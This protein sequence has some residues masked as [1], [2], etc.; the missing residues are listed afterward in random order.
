MEI[1]I[2]KNNWN[3][4]INY[5]QAA[6]DM[7]KA[8]IGGMAVCVEDEEGDW[9]IERPIILKQEISGGNCILDKEELAKYY[10]K[11]GMSKHYKNKNYRFLWWHSHHTMDAFWSATDLTAIQ[12]FNEGDFSFALVVNL[13]QEYKLRVS[14]WQPFEIHKDVDLN[15]L[16]KDKKVP[17]N[18][19]DEVE[20]LCDTIKPYTPN[21]SHNPSK[22]TSQVTMFQS[23]QTKEEKDFEKTY[24]KL[25]DAI[26]QSAGEVISKA[27]SFD[28]FANDLKK[29]D[30]QLKDKNLGIR[31]NIPNEQEM[32]TLE[33]SFIIEVDKKFMMLEKALI[34]D[35]LFDNGYTN[36]HYSWGML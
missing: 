26:E 3:K 20:L 36:S 5:A 32:Y 23:T 31:V 22:S 8:E 21:Y 17:K 11:I 14:V 4:V 30:K 6:Y 10:T 19:I 9:N 24:I 27:I 35:L 28:K 15:I 25:W 34:S 29:I 18:I 13:K 33:P 12:E 1:Y 16:G 7:H 2:S